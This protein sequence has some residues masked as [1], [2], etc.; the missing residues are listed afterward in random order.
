MKKLDIEILKKYANKCSAAHNNAESGV[1]LE[2]TTQKGYQLA[3]DI[4]VYANK[5][6]DPNLFKDALVLARDLLP[7]SSILDSKEIFEL[8][9]HKIEFNDKVAQVLINKPETILNPT[10]KQ[11]QKRLHKTTDEYEQRQ[12]LQRLSDINESVAIINYKKFGQRHL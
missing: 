7:Q 8:T 12:I 6:E 1:D 4:I 5:N 3:F 10:K 11:L 9:K 2:H